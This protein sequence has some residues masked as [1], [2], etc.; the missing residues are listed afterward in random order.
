MK[1]KTPIEFLKA[2]YSRILTASETLDMVNRFVIEDHPAAGCLLMVAD[3]L[4][5][6]ARQ[7]DLY[8]IDHKQTDKGQD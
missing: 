7:I 4:D 8:L 6:T 1:D 3:F 5:N 2:T